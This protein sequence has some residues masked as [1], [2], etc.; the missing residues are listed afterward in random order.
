VLNAIKKKKRTTKMNEEQL[1]FFTADLH[2][3]HLAM[4]E[5][6][7]RPWATTK[8]HDEGIIANWNA[9]VPK[10]GRV[11]VL[12]DISFRGPAETIELFERLNGQIY[13]IKGNHDKVLDKAFVQAALNNKIV[14]IKDYYRLAVRDP[15][16]N[17]R[18]KI[19]LC[20][21]PFLTWHGFGKGVWHA[22]G[23]SHGNLSANEKNDA[24]RH[25]VG[26][27]VNNYTPVSYMQLKA[28]M[29]TK[30]EVAQDHHGD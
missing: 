2:F 13:I 7:G 11:Y 28:I 18:Q 30:S 16:T 8:E 25:D 15:E 5:R 21:Y 19:V 29:A 23:H 17:L 26:V 6:F 9:V 1:P 20:H 27:D 12:G 24:K 4:V 3:G 22:H 14:W 10:S